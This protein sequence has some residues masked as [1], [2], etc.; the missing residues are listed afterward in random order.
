MYEQN[1]FLSP[2]EISCVRTEMKG[3]KKK[4]ERKPGVFQ[5]C[6]VPSDRNNIGGL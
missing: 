2:L 6:I 4:S 3:G 5:K 1:R